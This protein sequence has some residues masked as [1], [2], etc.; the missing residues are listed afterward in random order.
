MGRSSG[1]EEVEY[2]NMKGKKMNK[3]K[4]LANRQDEINQIFIG[5]EWSELDIYWRRAVRVIAGKGLGVIPLDPRRMDTSKLG[6]TKK[7]AVNAL[8]SSLS[9]AITEGFSGWIGLNVALNDLFSSAKAGTKQSTVIEVAETFDDLIEWSFPSEN[10]NDSSYMI[11][12]SARIL[13]YLGVGY[14]DLFREIVGLIVLGR[15]QIDHGA[16]KDQYHYYWRG[17]EDHV[18]VERIAKTIPI[19]ESFEG[20]LYTL[21]EKEYLESRARKIEGIDALSAQEGDGN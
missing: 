2:F 7:H 3:I 8:I 18:A 4:E 6:N 21:M 14:D 17:E 16:D 1:T 10:R 11:L 20:D 5:E 19:T 13:H 12:L 15:F 9:V